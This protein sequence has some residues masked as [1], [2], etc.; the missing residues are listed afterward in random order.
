[1]LVVKHFVMYPWF[2]GS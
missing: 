1:M 2:L